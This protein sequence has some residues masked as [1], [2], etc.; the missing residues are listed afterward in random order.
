[1]EDE[2]Q[3]WVLARGMSFWQDEKPSLTE[4]PEHDGNVGISSPGDEFDVLTTCITE[5]VRCKW[6]QSS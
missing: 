4:A 2:E 5:G 3:G 1:M 6:L